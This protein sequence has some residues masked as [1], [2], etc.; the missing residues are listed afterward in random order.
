[1]EH[2]CCR[3]GGTIPPSLL[4][5]SLYRESDLE[6]LQ[7]S[8]E[9]GQLLFSPLPLRTPLLRIHQAQHQLGRR[10]RVWGTPQ[11]GCRAVAL[12]WGTGGSSE[13]QRLAAPNTHKGDQGGGRK[14]ADSLM[15]SPWVW[16]PP[17]HTHPLP[18][19]IQP[20]EMQ[21]PPPC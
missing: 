11:V 4:R 3:L 18:R 15:L 17:C 6:P 20:L 16:K 9:G 1:M 19:R 12:L 8:S 13:G 5:I 2:V 21:L 7:H 10:V 14:M